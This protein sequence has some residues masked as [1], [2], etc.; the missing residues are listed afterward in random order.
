MN[1]KSTKEKLN[2]E[3]EE[4]SCSLEVM[5]SWWPTVLKSFRV[6]IFKIYNVW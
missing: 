2:D 5:R 6:E 1:C 3:K 4:E